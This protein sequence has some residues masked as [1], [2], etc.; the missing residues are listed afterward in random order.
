MKII[1]QL[2]GLIILLPVVALGTLRYQYTDADGPS[3]LFPGGELTTGTLYDG[4]EPDW[5]FTSDIQTIELQLNNPMSSRFVWALPVNGRLFVASGYM[6][7][8]L[9]RTWK[10]WAVEAFEGD[11][12]AV[13][14]INGVRYQRRLVRVLQG[15]VLDGVA[16]VMTNK[17]GSPTTRQAIETGNT[18][19][20]EVAPRG[21]E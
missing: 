11:G 16:S 2:L 6:G 9:G 19:V 15:G 21:R 12:N 7:S 10:H 17:Y 3:I 13:V 1:L 14:R 20:F 8:I 5:S 4:P 18:W